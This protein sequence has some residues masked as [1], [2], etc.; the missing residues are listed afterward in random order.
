MLFYLKKNPM[1]CEEEN[2][3]ILPSV[4]F[5]LPDNVLHSVKSVR[6]GMN[7]Q[8]LWM[9]AGSRVTLPLRAG[10]MVMQG[11]ALPSRWLRCLLW[12]CPCREAWVLFSTVSPASRPL[13]SGCAAVGHSL[14]YFKACFLFCWRGWEALAK[15][16]NRLGLAWLMLPSSFWECLGRCPRGSLRCW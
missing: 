7:L 2:T 15:G 10:G 8:V 11:T 14:R 1:S 12:P 3:Q 16:M 6:R 5:Y 13:A 4:Q 9:K